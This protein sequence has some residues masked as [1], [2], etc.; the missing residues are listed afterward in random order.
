MSRYSKIN[1][2]SLTIILLSAF[3]FVSFT[4][5]Q[6]PQE[7]IDSIQNN[8]QVSI[9]PE[10]PKAGD[11][12]AIHLQSYSTPLDQ[13]NISWIVG[14]VVK[15]KGYGLV[16]FSATAGRVGSRTTIIARV[17]TT[18]GSTVDK[19]ITIQP[20]DI[21]LLW[22]VMSYT[23]PFY[24]GKALFPHQGLITFT[25]VPNVSADKSVT[26]AL[27]SYVYTW[28]KGS[29]VLG[30]FS[31]YGK[32]TFTL[33]GSIISRPLTISV[34]VTSTDGISLGSASATVNPR[35]PEVVFYENSPLLG[36]LYNKSLSSFTM[37]GKEVS[38]AA[39]PFFFNTGSEPT[40]LQFKWTMNGQNIASQNDPSVITVRNAT[41]VSGN[42]TIGL[43]ISNALKTLQF[44][45]N[46]MS[47][48]FEKQNNQTGL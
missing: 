19:T 1:I 2:I 5:A 24:Q 26:K 6:T 20:A 4:N 46:S 27:G 44:A 28:K 15:E 39:I 30:D 45:S 37:L 22:Q 33:R 14:G 34:D 9:N 38:V 23:P 42:S 40:D 35:L 47:V 41:D 7:I 43:Q 17:V 32:N 21:D 48:T 31:G 25:A 12:V 10:F 13:A 29:D 16:D 18:N 36:V 3:S 11:E 8:I